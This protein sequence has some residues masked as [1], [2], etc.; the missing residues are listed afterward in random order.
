MQ[1]VTHGERER[2]EKKNINSGHLAMS[3][4]LCLTQQLVVRFSNFGCW[5]KMG[6]AQAKQDL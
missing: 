5:I 6:L 2:R 4:Q 1:K 3:A